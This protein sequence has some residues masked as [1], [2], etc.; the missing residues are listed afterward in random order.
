LGKAGIGDWALGVGNTGG[1]RRE[2]RGERWET[3]GERR[4]ALGVGK[5]GRCVMRDAGRQTRGFCLIEEECPLPNPPREGEGARRTK[6]R[7]RAEEGA[8]RRVAELTAGSPR[9]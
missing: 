4:G 8:R 6:L 9:L 1:G 3:R 7:G 5:G 2:V